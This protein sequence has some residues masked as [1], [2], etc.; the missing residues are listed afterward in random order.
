MFCLSIRVTIGT[1]AMQNK[2]DVA[3]LLSFAKIVIQ[4]VICQTIKTTNNALSAALPGIAGAL[5][6][7]E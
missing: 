4:C 3:S 6:L 7:Q 2:Y 1:E 5:L